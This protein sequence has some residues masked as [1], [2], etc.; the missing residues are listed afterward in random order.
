M[1]YNPNTPENRVR[2]YVRAL[3]A[4]GHN[5]VDGTRYPSYEEVMT[6][7]DRGGFAM[8]NKLITPVHNIRRSP[9]RKWREE[10]T[11]FVLRTAYNS[12]ALKG[13]AVGDTYQHIGAIIGRTYTAVCN[14]ASFLNI[15][16]EILKTRKSAMDNEFTLR[17]FVTG[18]KYETPKTSSIDL[19]K[20]PK[21]DRDT[22]PQSGVKTINLGKGVRNLSIVYADDGGVQI[23]FEG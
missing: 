6:A 3:N 9:K 7:Y 18:S 15:N 16:K 12:V 17:Y 1:C 21:A 20:K 23:T 13:C 2:D 19:T 10:E 11:A 8:A 22:S 4:L 14:R 5:I